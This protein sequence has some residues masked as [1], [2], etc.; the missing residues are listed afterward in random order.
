MK[1]LPAQPNRSLINGIKCLQVVI[2]ADQPIGSRE[3]ARRTGFEHTKVNRHL[4]TFL[5]L[6]M[7]EQTKKRTYFPG[8][9]IHVLAAQS[10]RASG[11]LKA[12]L[13][14][15]RSIAVDGLTVALGV[16]WDKNVCYLYHGRPEI[17]FE[18]G[19]SGVNVYPANHSSIGV[20]LTAIGKG[21][22]KIIKQGYMLLEDAFHGSGKTLS[23]PVGE[24]PIAALAYAGE[25]AGVSLPKLVSKL[26]EAAKK[27]Q[28]GIN[29]G[30]I[31]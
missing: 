25:F 15:I 13:P 10:L 12:A 24:P 30:S 23:V 21:D 9:G 27:I 18:G 7:L 14:E 8:P 19:I 11:L 22:Q 6:G 29:N 5:S 1:N 20:L 16:L 3:V 2:T 28:D 31:S 17:D 26:K 4:R